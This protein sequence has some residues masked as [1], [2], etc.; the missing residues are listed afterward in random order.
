MK[1]GQC[2]PLTSYVAIRVPAGILRHSSLVLS[3][4]FRQQRR[5]C[6]PYGRSTGDSLD[7][8]K[9]PSKLSSFP[10]KFIDHRHSRARECVHAR[11]NVA[12]F[13]EGDRL[14]HQLFGM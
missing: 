14:M 7:G 2:R 4:I 9:C 13:V 3:A 6:S 10:R 12:G 8:R 11:Q 5:F 1:H